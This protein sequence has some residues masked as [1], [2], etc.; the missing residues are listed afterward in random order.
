MRPS[1]KNIIFLKS[2]KAFISRTVLVDTVVENKSQL[3]W[4]QKYGSF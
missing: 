1:L 3:L 2:R 4:P